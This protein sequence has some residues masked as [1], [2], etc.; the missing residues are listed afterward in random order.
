M[1]VEELV[2]VKFPPGPTMNNSLINAESADGAVKNC[3]LKFVEPEVVIVA[4]T[5]PE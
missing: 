2:S 3:K 4:M 1:L 5:D